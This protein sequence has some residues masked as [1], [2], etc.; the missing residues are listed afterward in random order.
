L[1]LLY[2]LLIALPLLAR[3]EA[4]ARICTLDTDNVNAIHILVN[5]AF[6]AI[7]VVCN[8]TTGGS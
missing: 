6:G 2:L 8:T 3:R 5:K 4:G 7:V 1:I